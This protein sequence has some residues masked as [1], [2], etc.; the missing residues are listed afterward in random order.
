[1]V[2]F[3]ESTFTDK[4]KADVMVGT[5]ELKYVAGSEHKSVTFIHL[6]EKVD[7]LLLTKLLSILKIEDTSSTFQSYVDWTTEDNQLPLI[8]ELIEHNNTKLIFVNYDKDND[9]LYYGETSTKHLQE[10]IEQAKKQK[11][12][13]IID[14]L[15]RLNPEEQME[16][17]HILEDMFIV[18]SLIKAEKAKE[19]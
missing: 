1:M 12:Q 8:N 10:I 13:E 15:D 18:E 3:I 14:L 6:N 2:Q 11:E 9:N 16:F 17:L 5:E 19:Q 4:E 7:T